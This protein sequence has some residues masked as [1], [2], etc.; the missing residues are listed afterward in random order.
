[1]RDMLEPDESRGPIVWMA[2]NSVAA[3]LAMAVLLVGGLL[4]GL[5]IKQEVFPEFDLDMVTV[6]VPYPGASPAEVEQGIVLAIEEAVRG[7]DG[8]EEIT[9][10]AREGMGSVTIELLLGADAQKVLQDVKQEVDRIMSFPEE[11][12][13]PQVVLLTRRRQVLSVVVY[14]DVE[15]RALRELCEQVRGRLLRAPEITQVELSAARPLEIS[16][17]VPQDNLRAHNLTLGKIAQKVAGTAVELPGGGIKTQGGEL[18]LR[19]KERRDY[20]REFGDVPIV[21]SNDGTE[22]RLDDIATIIDGFEDTDQS[23]TFDG[24]RAML[25]DV[26]RVGEQTPLEVADAVRRELDK[27][28]SDLPPGVGLSIQ[29]DMSDIYR[30]RAELLLRNG[31]IGLVLVFGLLTIFLEVRLAFWV[32][33]G[34]PISFLGSFLF[35]PAMGMSINMVSMFAFLIA[36]GIVVDDAIVVGENVYEHH[37]RGM[38]FLAAAVRGAREVAMPVT[39]SILT[40]VVAF[41]PLFF[42]PGIMGKV[43]RCIPAVVVTV[44]LISLVESLFILPAHLGHGRE[45]RGRVGG[46]FH[47]QQQRFSRWFSRMI[48]TRYGPFLGLA[49]GH[50]YVTVAIGVAVLLVTIGLIASGRMG[51]QMFPRAESDSGLAT[52]VLPYGCSVEETKRVRDRLVR[53]AEDIAQEYGRDRLVRGI[54]AQVGGSSGSGGGPFRTTS[55]SGGHVAKIEVFLTPS[56]Q[57][58]I[59]TGEFVKLWRQRTGVVPGIDWIMFQADARG[60]GSG[61]ALSVELSH[62]EIDVLERASAELAGALRQFAAAEDVDDGFSPGKQQFDFKI[63]PEASSLGLAALDVARQVR[64]AFYGAEALRQQRGR[65]EVKVMVRLPESERVSEYNLEELLIRT[66][67]GCE[68][69]LREATAV[70]RGRAYTS[71]DRREG[72]RI[73]TVSADVDPPSQAGRILAVLKAGALPALERKYAGLAYGFEGKQADMAES[74]QGLGM[75]FAMAVLVM[76]AL[77]AIPFRSYVQPAIIMVS[78]PFGIVGAVVGHLIMGYSLSVMSMMGIVALSGV[79]VND[80]LV[81]IEFANRQHR[82]GMSASD[83]VRSA[84][85]RRFRPIML[86]TLTTFGGLMP[87]IF[88]TSMQARFLIPMAISL[89]YGILFATAISLL[90][91]PCLF[92]IVED[93]RGRV[94]VGLEHEECPMTDLQS[95]RVE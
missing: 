37:Q 95:A 81:L 13:E 6:S 84:G 52:A 79:V 59:G 75:G 24:K 5:R 17:E 36:L 74:M 48:E 69:P 14:G 8:V 31:R 35:L 83:A 2:R 28:R 68:I 15:E 58:P 12:E 45:R 3:N 16:I 71:I 64:H 34:I 43:F 39:F 47:R 30:Q 46:W 65:N 10:S 42:V 87:M 62:P 70:T 72:R 9:A 54:F 76:Y 80:S 91:V 51:M 26:Y 82:S 60:P 85:I 78:I 38:P 33:M 18:L 61:K 41:M 77:L 44:F 57:R 67:A 22:V 66:P 4:C 7:L 25:A 86:T 94:P 19:M 55:L 93:V 21:T 40:N 11:A 88:E 23:A 49:L 50:R 29:N 27:I 1:M 53:A 92:L 20:G 90:L 89:G 63:R 73:V 56:K 32:S